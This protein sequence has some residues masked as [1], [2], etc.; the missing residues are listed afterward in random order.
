[1]NKILEDYKKYMESINPIMQYEQLKTVQEK[2]KE[3]IGKL[4]HAVN[5]WFIQHGAT[6]YIG[7]GNNG[8]NGN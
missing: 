8:R 4:Q 5:Q 7:K 1:M 3:F 2:D 6:G